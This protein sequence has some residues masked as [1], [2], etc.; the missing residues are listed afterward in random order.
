MRRNIII[1]PLTTDSS[2]VAITPL[3]QLTEMGGPVMWVLLGLAVL[4]LVA[5]FYLIIT[6]ALFA[7]RLTLRLRKTLNQWQQ[8]PSHQCAELLNGASGWFTRCNPLPQMIRAAMTSSLEQRDG[9][10]VREELARRSQQALQPFEAP[11]KIIEVI[12]ALA[13]LLGLLGT[14]MGMMSAFSAMSVAEGQANASQ[15]SGGIYEALTTTA[16]GLVVAIPFAAIA[17]WAEFRLR[18]LNLMMND[19]L[20]RVITTPIEAHEPRATEL[21]AAYAA[22]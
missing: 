10:E 18:R 12:A 17:A 8:R 16:A 7:P 6:G 15:L 5:F 19:T 2:L 22:G 9:T 3:Q 14:V 13:P 1:N 11:L 4:G 20:V 21:N